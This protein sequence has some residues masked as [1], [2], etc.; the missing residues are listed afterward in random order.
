VIE[1]VDSKTKQQ[2]K[3]IDNENQGELEITR[4]IFFNM[5]DSVNNRL[6]LKS[7]PKKKPK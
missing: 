4:S 2:K 1:L 7:K 5:K 6:K 3:T